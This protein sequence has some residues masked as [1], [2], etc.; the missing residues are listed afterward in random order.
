MSREI[1]MHWLKH[2]FDFLIVELSEYC[3]SC[4]THWFIQTLTLYNTIM[5]LKENQVPA[6]SHFRTGLSYE[7]VC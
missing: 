4:W 1:G 7:P 2:I 3:P 6:C 5:Q